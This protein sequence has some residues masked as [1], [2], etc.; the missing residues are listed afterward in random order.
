M[1]KILKENRWFLIPYLIFFVISILLL[2]IN[3]KGDVF[4]YINAHHTPFWDQFFRFGTYL[5][6]GTLAAIV[7]LLVLIL[8]SIRK[9]LIGGISL[10]TISVVI[11]SLKRLVFTDAPRPKNYFTDI[12]LHLIDQVN[13]H[14]SNAMPSGHTAAGFALF[15]SLS[16]IFAER[17]KYIAFVC[18]ILAFIVGYSRLY[19]AQHFLADV[20]FG[21]LIGILSPLVFFTIFASEQKLSKIK[22][23][24]VVSIK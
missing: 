6:D 13:V 3:T 14:G 22:N 20:T 4:L 18:F 8:Y 12:D 9:G 5:G 19:L 24:P 1:K 2:I 17:N 23:K 7:M 11:Q 16:I 15:M 10:I 21:S